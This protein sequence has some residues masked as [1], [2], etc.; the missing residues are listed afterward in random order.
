M[1]QIPPDPR[2]PLEGAEST[3]SEQQWLTRRDT[4]AAPL[5]EHPRRALFS[6]A[7]MHRAHKHLRRIFFVGGILLALV[8]LALITIAIWLRHSMH[9]SL[10]QLD[11]T[12]HAPGLAQPATVTRDAQGVPSISAASLDDVL[13]AQGFVTAQDRLW[14]MDALRR[15]ASGNLAELLG[16]S[17]AE[18]DRVQRTLQIRAAADRAVAVLPADQLHQLERYAAGVNA[19]ITQVNDPSTGH[20][21]VEFH[22]LHYKPAP[23]TPR[24]TLLVYLAMVQDLS[25][26]FPVKLRREALAQHL[27]PQLIAD[28]YPVGSWRDHPPTQPPPDLTTPVP[29]VEQ[30]PLDR[31]QSQLASPA[32]ILRLAHEL[33][34]AQCAECRAG[35]N[36]WAIAGGHSASGA[37][38]LSND[39]HLT[40]N[41]PDIWYEATLHATASTTSPALDVAGF[42]LP[43]VPF[44]IVG[45]N[46]HVA[47]GFTNLGA[48]V[49]D[50]HV[51][52]TRGSGANLEYQRGDG[53]WQPIGHHVEH[54]IVRGGHDITLDVLTTTTRFGQSMIAARTAGVAAI[55]TPIITP[56]ARSDHRTLSL[57]WT[58]YD[59]ST[60]TAPF[61]AVDMASDGASLVS[62]LS[63]FGGPSLNLVYADD[64]NHIG[65]HA[66]GAI[67]VRGPAT[68][69]ARA[70]APVAPV[71]AAESDEED[72]VNQ[73]DDSS[74]QPALQQNHPLP[75][76]TETLGYSIGSDISPVPVDALDASQTWSG[77]IPFSQLPNVVDPPNGI[78]A[79]ANSRITPNDY[80]YAI[81]LN[82]APPY[83]AE[84]IYKLLTGRN[85]L[86]PADMLAIQTDVHSEFDLVFAQRLAY[87]LDHASP[88]ALAHDKTRLHQAADILRAWNG[89]VTAASAAPSI[90]AAT[91]MQL[92]PMLLLPQIAAHDKRN[93]VAGKPADIFPLYDWAG[94]TVALEEL[95]QHTPARWLPAGFSNWNDLLATTLT[96]AL[97]E[98]HA[99]SNLS[100]WQYGQQH[101]VAI[102]HPVLST[103]RF[104]DRL[105]GVPTGTGT[106]ANDG[107]GTTIKASG[108]HFGPSERFTADLAD[109]Q[110]TNA[111][112]TTGQ[113]GNP[114]SANYLDQFLPWLNGTTF[115]LP[116]NPTQTTHALVLLP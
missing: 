16:S 116:L 79:T 51:E 83:R 64:H 71:S 29:E 57:A 37:P 12:L 7:G 62:A 15:H 98:A 23:W 82:W 73:S 44:V 22:L 60:V 69:H 4:P 90:L 61:L 27:S 5:T 14:Q 103:L 100:T 72:Q 6:N 47:W 66:L 49:Q 76:P 25:T 13:F 28:L 74:N 105:L 80:P 91:R 115:H 39:M 77:Y 9:A 86:T 75:A 104:V 1:T 89:D 50:V 30:I 81:T 96:R 17:M 40:L 102:N 111:N 85:A 2:G 88:T 84:R 78:L 19:F 97:H 113:S 31:T 42:T 11:G 99:P 52:H 101:P 114:S 18:H 106:H 46:Q 107:D 56:L 24:D 63:T 45:R 41:V 8:A 43:G 48:D 26:G 59:P 55:E 94:Q 67:P 95:L 58:I 70:I 35:S 68:Q 21:P 87:A 112:I 93:H 36:N 54:I 65:Y 110:A 34:A 38:L 92:L 108:P 20:L 109:P 10:A 3:P 33:P 53:S 32:D